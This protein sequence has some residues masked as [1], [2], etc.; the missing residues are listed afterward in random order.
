MGLF[1]F[2][3]KEP[4]ERHLVKEDFFVAEV[5]YHN[6]ET[7][8]LRVANPD[9]RKGSKTLVAEGKVMEKIYHYSYVNKPVKI[10][11]GDGK[12]G[13]KNA[14]MIYIAGE[15]VGYIKDEDAKH[16]KEILS[17]K[18]IKYI[19]AFIRGGEYKVVS[20]NGEAIKRDESVHVNLR[21][22]YA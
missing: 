5:P 21:I 3:K 18:S 7:A 17:K 19:S 22:A 16:V 20:E 11:S 12:N 15:H 10:I 1:D 13:R 14:L 4:E 9:W 6:E 8:K 2:L